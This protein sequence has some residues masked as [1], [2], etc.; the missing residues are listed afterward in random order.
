MRELFGVLT[1]D[2]LRYQLYLLNNKNKYLE[3]TNRL[4]R[5][6]RGPD[7][8]GYVCLWPHTSRLHAPLILPS[9]GKRLLNKCLANSSFKQVQERSVDK[10][11]QISVLIGHRGKERLPLLLATIRSIASQIDVTLECIVVEQD[12]EPKIR[13][14]LPNWVKYVFLKT[15]TKS[16]I[17]NRSAAFNFGA[18]YAIGKTLVLHDNDMLVSTTY[19]RDIHHL[20]KNGYEAMNT[21]R[22]VFYLK[23]SH[24]ERVIAS[25]NCLSTDFPDYI[26]QN[27]EAGGSMAITKEAYFR[28]GGMD[29]DF[30]GWGGEDIEFWERCSLLKRWIW[31]YEPIIHLWHKSQPLKEQKNNP[32][33]NRIKD[34]DDV[35]LESRIQSLKSK[36]HV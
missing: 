36:K 33:L 21:K 24:S 11:I 13:E 1:K 5:I 23:R 32:N 16:N 28:I 9:L 27:L 19:C 25:M 26:V 34:L 3:L 14:Y 2:W 30:V 29:E 31:G 7:N 15:T 4:E 6:A 18:R 8:L 22:Y 12:N 17:Y 35:S 20:V 10:Q